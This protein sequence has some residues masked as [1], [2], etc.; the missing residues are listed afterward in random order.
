[1]TMLWNILPTLPLLLS[2]TI[3]SDVE[4]PPCVLLAGAFLLRV[5]YYHF[6]F[7]PTVDVPPVGAPLLIL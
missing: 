1:M 2:L 5:A 3:R 4:A 7:E 6:V